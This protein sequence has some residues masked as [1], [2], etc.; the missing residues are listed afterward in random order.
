M[1]KVLRA[2]NLVKGYN[3]HLV[4][5]DLLKSVINLSVSFILLTFKNT[6]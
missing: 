1:K 4:T 5:S 3:L 2:Y 6:G